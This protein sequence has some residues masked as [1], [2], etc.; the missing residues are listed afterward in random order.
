MVHAIS[1]TTPI[2]AITTHSTLPTLPTTCSFK[3]RSA[4]VIFQ[5][6]VKVRIAA[7]TVRPRVHP[8]IEQTR[9]IGVGLRDRHA[10]P[11]PRDAAIRK[12]G[13]RLA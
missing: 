4:G 1:I 7:W 11:E 12:A 9:H 8:D 13:Q 6:Q 2:V 3:G 10:R 5:S